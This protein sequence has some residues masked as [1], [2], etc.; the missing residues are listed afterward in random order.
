MTVEEGN[1][2]TNC[3]P[4]SCLFGL[5]AYCSINVVSKKNKEKGEICK[6]GYGRYFFWVQ[7]LN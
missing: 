6:N 5:K 7:G 4:V 3:Y 1:I 2:I